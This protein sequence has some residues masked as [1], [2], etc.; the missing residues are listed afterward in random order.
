MNWVTL[1]KTGITVNKNGFGAL[2]IQRV[3]LDAASA[4]L[5]KA[6]KSGINFFD[7]ARFYTDS[8]E[9]IGFALSS[10]RNKIYIASKTMAANADELRKQLDTSLNLLKTDYIDIY[11]LHNPGFCPKPGDGTGLYE[12][13]LEAKDKGMIRHIGIT[14]HRLAVAVEAAESG[15]YETIQFPFSYLA[16]DGEVR[17]V[18]LC[19]ERDIG[20]IAMKA[21]SG[22]LITNAAAAYAYIARYDNVLPI[23][24]IQKEEELDQFISYINEPPVYNEDISRIIEKDRKMLGGEFCRGCGYCMPCPS[25]IDIPISARMSLMI[26]RAP[27]SVYL[28][29]EWQEK[30]KRIDDCFDCGSCKS[31]CPYGLDIPRLLKENLE[32]YRQFI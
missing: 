30:M 21:L 14:S 26:R 28:N 29:D 22:G 24:G 19:R 6:Y 8:E 10:V 4:L 17:L 9:K 2:P 18:K 12:A 32:D 31:K 20:F 23:W 5:K 15:L 1:G 3:S 13:L 27:V 11:Q 7:T 25:D 16:T